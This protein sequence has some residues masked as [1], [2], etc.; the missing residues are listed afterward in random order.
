MC[1]KV[2]KHKFFNCAKIDKMWAFGVKGNGMIFADNVK[3]N[4][5]ACIPQICFNTSQTD[6]CIGG[7]L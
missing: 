7:G 6:T 4:V 5:K 2:E 1:P 3:G